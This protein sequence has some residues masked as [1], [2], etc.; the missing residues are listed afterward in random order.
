METDIRFAVSS[1]ARDRTFSNR[2]IREVSPFPNVPRSRLTRTFRVDVTV[3]AA[4]VDRHGARKSGAGRQGDAKCNRAV[5]ES[6]YHPRFADASR[7]TSCRQPFLFLLPSSLSPFH[8]S[9]RLLFFSPK[10]PW[11]PLANANPLDVPSPSRGS[12]ARSLARS[13]VGI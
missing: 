7:F 1:A 5:A 11:F 2:C 8:F 3:E 9:G 10:N 4:E 13:P 12:P 6:P